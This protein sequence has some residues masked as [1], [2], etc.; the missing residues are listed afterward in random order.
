[1][2]YYLFTAFADRLG[3]ARV[4]RYPSFRIPA[5]ALTALVLMLWLFPRFI[6]WLRHHQAGNTQVREDTPERHQKTKHG[7]PTMGGLFILACV[8]VAALLFLK[9][10]VKPSIQKRFNRSFLSSVR[11]LL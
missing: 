8:L 4:F 11:V 7:T 10:Q 1:M 2:L 3:P 5:A 9:S 6:D